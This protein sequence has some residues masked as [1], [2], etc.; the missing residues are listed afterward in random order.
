MSKKDTPQARGVGGNSVG[1]LY[2]RENADALG[3]AG[4]EILCCGL[5]NGPKGIHVLIP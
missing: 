1:V 2:S 3:G 5:T 4:Q